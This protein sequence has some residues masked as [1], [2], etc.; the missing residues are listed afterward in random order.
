MNL[1]K[2]NDTYI[3]HRFSNR[4]E[5]L[6]KRISGIGG[7]DASALIGMNPYKTNRELWKQKTGLVEDD[8]GGNS[9]TEYGQNAEPL[10]RELLKLK[11][12]NYDIQ[13]RE[14]CI[15]QSKDVGWLLYSPDG[16]IYTQD[17]R[18]GILE[19]K[20]TF[21]QNINMYNNWKNQVPNHYYIQVLHGLLVTGFE[22]VIF[23]AELRFAWER[24]AELVTLEF[25]REDVLED[26]EW[27]KEKEIKEYQSYLD[28]KE[29]NLIIDM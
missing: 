12:P 20:T 10:L 21:I 4:E 23:H 26:L 16:L 25:R 8:F 27:L 13:H 2:T 11:H 5:W 17:N 7:S 6:N 28:K 14:N 15:L 29:P 3:V 22:F 18:K 1:Y 24:N 19:I 9:F